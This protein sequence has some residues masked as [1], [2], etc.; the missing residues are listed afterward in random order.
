MTTTLSSSTASS[1]PLLVLGYESTRQAGNKLHQLIDRADVDVTLK[2]AGLRS[3]TLTFGYATYAGALVC[4]SMHAAADF[5]TLVDDSI[6]GIGMVYV[7][8]GSINV[9]LD[10][11]TRQLWTVAVEFQEVLL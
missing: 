6:A 2:S 7:A 4:E 11:E 10:D 8:S 1:T 9:A 3:G 5:I